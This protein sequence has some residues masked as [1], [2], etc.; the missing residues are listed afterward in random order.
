[1]SARF[2][3]C[4]WTGHYLSV[5]KYAFVDIKIQFHVFE[6]SYYIDFDFIVFAKTIF[7]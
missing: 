7:I 1:M 4:E 5:Q 3:T 6:S 2:T